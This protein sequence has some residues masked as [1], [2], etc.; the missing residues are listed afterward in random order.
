MSTPHRASAA[1]EAIDLALVALILGAMVVL[2]ASAWQ[3]AAKL[4]RRR[5]KRRT[6]LRDFDAEARER[7][8]G[9]DR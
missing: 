6:W 5:Q 3:G 7:Q 2:A 8:D 1:A 9:E 4:A